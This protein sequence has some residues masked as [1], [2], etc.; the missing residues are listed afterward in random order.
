MKDATLLMNILAKVL[1][2]SDCIASHHFLPS[3]SV[4]DEAHSWHFQL[5]R[6]MSGA[7]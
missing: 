4:A 3:A 5:L 2:G 7:A 6:A 1:P